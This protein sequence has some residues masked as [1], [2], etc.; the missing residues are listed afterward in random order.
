[1]WSSI[2]VE[3]SLVRENIY[4]MSKKGWEIARYLMKFLDKDK[5]DFHWNYSHECRFEENIF[6]DYKKIKTLITE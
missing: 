4:Y 2:W 6:E 1:M 5:E 3:I